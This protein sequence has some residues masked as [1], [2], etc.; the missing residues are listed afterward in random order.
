MGRWLFATTPFLFTWVAVVGGGEQWADGI[1]FI[2]SVVLLVVSARR[3]RRE[4]LNHP[5]S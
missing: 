1:G 5:V 4:E 3:T 2:T